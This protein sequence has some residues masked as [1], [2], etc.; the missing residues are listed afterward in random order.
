MNHKRL[1]LF[2]GHYGSG[3]TNIALNYAL[4]LR[5]Q[6]LPVTVAD[7]DIVN[8]YF[9]TKDGE[10]QLREAGIRLISSEYANSNVD[11]PALPGE[12]YSLVDDKSVC[13][14]I[15]V[16][17]DDR[18]ALALGRYVP[19][20]REE[21]DYEMLFVLNRARPLTRTA[22]DALEVFHEIEAAC[23]LPFTAIVNNTNLGPLT[24]PEDVIA[25]ARF[26]E[27]V[28]ARTGLPVKMNCAMRRF[29]AELQDTVSNFFPIDI[30]QL[31][32]MEKEG[33]SLGKINL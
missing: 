9:R 21:G 1:T 16:G 14:V 25:G 6:G 12:A 4:W 18:G 11:L 8:P 23:A 29:E 5:G 17:G 26:A 3:K 15:D 31:Y 28:G 22:E 13:G 7:L 27:E 32:Y 33:T 30:M 2:A 10:V 24:R 20:I 19:A